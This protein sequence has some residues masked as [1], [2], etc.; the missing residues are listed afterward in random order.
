L[1]HI[2][3]VPEGSYCMNRLSH[4]YFGH[5]LRDAC[6]TALLADEGDMIFLDE[7]L[8]WP[9]TTHYASAFGL[10]VKRAG[11]AF[12]STLR[13]YSDLSQGRLRRQRYQMLRQRMQQRFR[14]HSG[15]PRPVY[16]RRGSTGS[17]REILNESELCRKLSAEGFEIVDLVSHD[18][19]DRF[20][21][22]ANAP[23]VVSLEGSHLNHAH[24]AMK[25]GSAI[26][27]LIPGARPAAIHR[28]VSH[29]MGMQFGCVVLESAGTEFVIN[30]DE[31]MR[32]L[33]LLT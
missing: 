11:A 28:V 12:V 3:D 26:L 2:E 17:R 25:S 29:A 6:S 1:G 24:L 20:G 13:I 5:W 33:D 23:V 21:K 22:L 4:G 8:D 31:V 14:A 19:A 18:F 9:D 30:P 32:T 16:L 27:A 7:R 10:P 15:S